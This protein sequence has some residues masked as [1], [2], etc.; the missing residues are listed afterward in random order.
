M[1]F[2][3]MVRNWDVQVGANAAHLRPWMFIS[4][5]FPYSYLAMKHKVGDGSP[6]SFWK[7]LWGVYLPFSVIF[8]CL[9]HL[10][11]FHNAPYQ[12]FTF[13][14]ELMFRRISI[15]LGT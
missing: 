1:V 5:V 8:P 7:D 2:S 11:T 4:Q 13:Y 14:R 6:I 9:Y 3:P 12:M 15:S 10:S